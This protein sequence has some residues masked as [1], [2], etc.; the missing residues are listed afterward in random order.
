MKKVL[1]L[2]AL[3]L[4]IP[5][6]VFAE[7]G[8]YY[9]N[10]NGIEM[11]YEEYQHLKN[12]GFEDFEIKYM[13]LVD[14][15]ENKNVEGGVVATSDKYLKTVGS[16]LQGY[17]TYEISK[18]E[19]ESGK[20]TSRN[21]FARISGATE[22]TYKRM[23]TSI[24]KSGNYYRF[25][26]LLQWKIM[27]ATRSYDIN[28]I[29][30]QNGAVAVVN[31]PA[32]YQY[33]SYKDGS[34]TTETIYN[35]KKTSTGG[36]AS[37]KLPSDSNVVS[38]QSKLTFLV[39]KV[40]DLSTFNLRAIGDYSHATSNVSEANAQKYSINMGGINL[41]SSISSKYDTIVGNDLSINVTW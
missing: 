16:P 40:T 5:A 39:S 13:S 38:L 4:I 14:F 28:A 11:T 2:F 12:L 32:L 20:D 22:T 36:G 26:N 8:V 9:T 29:G 37:F 10:K 41:D 18:E 3:L 6:F 21:P 25:T 15:Q 31:L 17:E 19:Y 30:F 7:D 34:D 24:V 33:I 35:Y 23:T 1:S 27:P